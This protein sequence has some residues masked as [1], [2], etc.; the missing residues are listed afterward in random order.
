MDPVLALLTLAATA[1]A[2]AALVL[3]SERG[4]TGDRTS[5]EVLEDQLAAW[6]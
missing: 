4:R 6:R 1:T 2:V 5:D 3:P